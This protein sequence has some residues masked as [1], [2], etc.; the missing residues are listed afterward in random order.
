MH[1][2]WLLYHGISINQFFDVCNRLHVP[3]LYNNEYHDMERVVYFINH[4]LKN[5]LIK[6]QIIEINIVSF[7]KVAHYKRIKFSNQDEEVL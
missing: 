4:T 3:S 1:F 2:L 6:I 5:L 7:I